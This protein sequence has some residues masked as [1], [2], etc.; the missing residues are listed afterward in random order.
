MNVNKQPTQ[1]VS[2]ATSSKS[3]IKCFTIKRRLGKVWKHNRTATNKANFEQA[4]NQ[5][6]HR[7]LDFKNEQAF[8]KTLCE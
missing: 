5:L 3:D 7:L 1:T 8:K 2:M 6:K 4:N